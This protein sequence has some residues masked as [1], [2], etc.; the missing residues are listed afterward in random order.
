VS[1]ALGDPANTEVVARVEGLEVTFERRGVEVRALRGVSLEIRRGEIL[2]IVGESGSGKTVLGLSLLGLLPDEPKPI[3][4]GQ[5][6]VLGTDMLHAPDRARRERRRRDLGAVFQDPAT[7]LNPT[8]T[9]GRQLAEVTSSTQKV[10]DLLIS[11]GI[12]DP[13]RRLKSFP[14]QLSGGQQQRVMIAMAIASQPALVVADEPTTALDV[15]VQADI[16]RLISRLRDELGCSFAFIT[17]DLS[18]AAEVA[19]RIA[20]LYGG[21][22]MEVGPVQDVLQNPAHP[23]TIGL[24]GSRLHL[25]SPRDRPVVSLPGEVPDAENAQPGCPFAP[26]CVL[27]IAEC[28]MQ[29]IPLLPVHDGRGLAACIRLGEV[30]APDLAS[31]NVELWQGP[32]RDERPVVRLVGVTKSFK[33]RGSAK[34]HGVQALQGIDL[35]IGGGE[36]VALVGESGSGKTTLLR[37]LAGLE[38][39][40]G[41]TVEVADS[42][43]QMIFQNAVA[44]LT[45]W[46]SVREQIGE[47]L[48]CKRLTRREVDDEVEMALQRVGLPARIAL[49]RPRQL[50]G[51][52][53]QRVAIARAIVVPPALL[54]ADE[55]TSSL[56]ISLRAVILNLLNRLRRELGFAVVFV[57]HDLTAARVIADRIAVMHDGAIVELGDPDTICQH[58]ASDYTRHLL[59][60][61]PGEDYVADWRV[62]DPR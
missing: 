16:L 25:G 36:S 54:L 14:H 12:P 20:V 44:S 30:A 18:V 24:L 7:S 8:M 23:Y 15:S 35:T 2:G 51:G 50:S 41:G 45:P 17:H 53:A 46:L 26:R 4:T 42:A 38:S 40:D 59:D 11:V 43:P 55:A 22:L 34:N 32:Q 21:K 5:V 47:R 31:L 29:H 49:A 61:L 10:I 60:S 62:D 33:I 27:A 28:S 39:T 3:V 52:Q 57:T 1:E 58:P 56:D 6:D 13:E 37:I 9:I 48:A 19:D